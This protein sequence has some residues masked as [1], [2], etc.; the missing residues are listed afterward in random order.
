MPA[1]PLAAAPGPLPW[2]PERRAAPAPTP[3]QVPV[4]SRIGVGLVLAGAVIVLVGAV[5]GWTVTRML[6]GQSPMSTMTVAGAGVGLRAHTDALGFRTQVPDEWIE[7][8]DGPTV[9]SFVSP[10]GLERLVVER[11]TSAAAV[12][13][14]L[15]GFLGAG[16]VAPLETAQPLPTG[17]SQ[18]VHRTLTGAATSWLRIVPASG[19]VWVV[20]LSAPSGNTEPVSEALFQVLADGFAP[21]SG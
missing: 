1:G 8:R 5:G 9:V 15:T 20:R 14:G 12:N 2:E 10:D 19:G 11:A 6:G 3:A 7:R 18:L 4:S 17:A 16:V 21:G 13:G